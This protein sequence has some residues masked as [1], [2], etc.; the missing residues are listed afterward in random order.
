[1][2][3][4]KII[5]T[6]GP[7]VDSKDQIA[8][9]ITSGMDIARLNFSHGSHAEHLKRIERVREVRA[10]LNAAVALMLDTKGPEIRTGYVVEH[11]PVL[12]HDNDIV[13]LIDETDDHARVT[14]IDEHTWVIP[15]TH[16]HLAHSVEAGA[17][18]LIDDGLIEMEICRIA[19]ENI[20]CRVKNGGALTSRK[21]L[22]LP[23][24]S[25]DL[26]TLT[27]SDEADLLFGIEQGIDFIAASFIRSAQDVRTIKSFLAAHGGADISVIAKIE[28]AE[29]VAHIEE[30]ID[31]S[32]GIMVA[33]GD[34]GVEVDAALVPHLQK[35]IIA[36][37]R[38]KHTPV[39]TATQMLDSMMR[40]PRPTRAEVADVANAIY[41]GTD[42]IMLSG[43][44]AKGTYPVEALRMMAK[45]AEA[46]E[47]YISEPAPDNVVYATPAERVSP[48]VGKACVQAAHIIDAR[49]IV[50]PT[51]SGRTAR[52]ISNLRPRVPIYAVTQRARVMRKM[53]LLWGVTP[54]LGQVEHVSMRTALEQARRVVCAQG[55]LDVGDIA[56]FTAGDARTSPQVEI[57]G[58]DELSATTNVMS[59]VEIRPSDFEED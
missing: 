45:I 59:V 10:Q 47:P 39:I 2:K 58:A 17:S 19:G 4:T 56:V 41:D 38:A 51:T 36:Y 5:A 6:L 49:A 25:V 27:P 26:P 40:N 21:S 34:L 1:M 32:D 18:I 11:Q 9:L 12:L 31:V 22:N 8:A 53:Q 46:S 30:I 28:N 42:A 48:T 23:G 13:H 3:R 35:Q 37:A 15:Q 20:I 7:A 33:R 43:E 50:T 29:G 24:C 14:Q 57:P 52:L 44:T 16:P 54:L 55:L